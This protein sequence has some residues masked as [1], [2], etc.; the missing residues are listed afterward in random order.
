MRAG[1]ASPPAA[2]PHAAGGLINP[3]SAVNR[4][5]PWQNPEPASSRRRWCSDAYPGFSAPQEA[6]GHL[7][8]TALLPGYLT[9][10]RQLV[11]PTT[12]IFALL[13]AVFEIVVGLLLISRGKWVKQG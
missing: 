4:K 9:L 12:T 11:M 13:L 8:E 3:C 7:A 6:R 2:A 1:R 10:W 5:P